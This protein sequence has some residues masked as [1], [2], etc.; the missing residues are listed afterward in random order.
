MRIKVK[1]TLYLKIVAKG[2]DLDD[3]KFS[4]TTKKCED[5]NGIIKV[6]AILTETGKFKECIEFEENVRNQTPGHPEFNPDEI[7]RL[8]KEDAMEV[9]L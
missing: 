8:I 3:W 5:N 1:K 2:A 4:W 7:N 9:I 6:G